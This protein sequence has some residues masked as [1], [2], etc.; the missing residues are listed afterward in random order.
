MPNTPTHCSFERHQK[1]AGRG[2]DGK[3]SVFP[4]ALLLSSDT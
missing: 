2:Y 4:G 1:A 3:R